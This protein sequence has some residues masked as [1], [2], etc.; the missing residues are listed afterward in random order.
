ME[1]GIALSSADLRKILD[2][3]IR[4]K[5]LDIRI[6]AFDRIPNDMKPNTAVIMNNQNHQQPGQHWLTLFKKDEGVYEFWDSFG[7]NP[8]AYG[9]LKK[10]AFLRNC[11]IVYHNKSIQYIFSNLCGF[12]SIFFLQK[13][14]RGFDMD[15]II[16]MFGSNTKLNDTIILKEFNAFKFK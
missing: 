12:Y 1:G 13:R 9:L 10:H 3:D 5:N 14:F 15:A 16:S 11:E 6:C 2:A 4:L 7:L 8:S